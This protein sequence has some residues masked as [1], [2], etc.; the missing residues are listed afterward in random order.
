MPYFRPQGA[1]YEARDITVE[2]CTFV[3]CQAPISYVGVDGATVRYNTFY[4]PGKWV[5][6][7]LQETTAEGFAPCRNGRFEDNLVVFRRAEVSTFVNVGPN[8]APETFRFARNLWYC[9]DRPDASR[10]TLPTP[11]TDGL[12]GVDPQLRDPGQHDFRPRNDQAAR[13]GASAFRPQARSGEPS[14]E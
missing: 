6:R 12:Y 7:I 13:Y 10:P 14:D 8:T 11:E 5:L 2:G 9:E 1:R 4:R 3:G